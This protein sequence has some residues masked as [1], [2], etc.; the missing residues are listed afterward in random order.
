MKLGVLLEEGKN[1]FLGAFADVSRPDIRQL[2]LLLEVYFLDDLT[3]ENA[4][5]A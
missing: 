2:G 5:G 3:V 1:G 4:L